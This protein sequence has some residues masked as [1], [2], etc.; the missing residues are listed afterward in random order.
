M[1]K[2]VEKAKCLKCGS[3]DIINVFCP[4]H[5]W[6]PSSPEHET[7]SGARVHRTCRNCGYKWGELPL[8]ATTKADGWHVP[9]VTKT[10]NDAQG[11][12][13]CKAVDRTTALAIAHDHNDSVRLEVGRHG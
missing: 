1:E 7:H 4:E 3:A 6:R 13:V 5:E 2:Y 8:D 12:L 10:V 11:R 9:G